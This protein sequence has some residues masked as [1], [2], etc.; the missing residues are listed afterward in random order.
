VHAG[1]TE[2]NSKPVKTV[3][4]DIR[5][6][7]T[8]NRTSNKLR[9]GIS[10]FQSTL[11][12]KKR[13]VDTMLKKNGKRNRCYTTKCAAETGRA[14]N[15]DKV[16]SGEI[17]SIKKKKSK[18][19][20]K[21]D[22][23]KYVVQVSSRT[24]YRI[25]LHVTDVETGRVDLTVK[26]ESPTR[27]TD[28][29][30]KNALVK[31]GNYFDKVKRERDNPFSFNNLSW[32]I[33]GS[34]ILTHGLFRDM[35]ESGY[36][37]KVRPETRN[38]FY[39]NSVFQF[40]ASYNYFTG[41]KVSY[42][43]FSLVEIG[44]LAGYSVDVI[45]LFKIVPLIGAGYNIYYMKEDDGKKNFYYDPQISAVVDINYLLMS[46]L[47]LVVSPAYTLFFEKDD[48]GKYFGVHTGVSVIF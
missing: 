30:V 18:T 12:V 45:R 13:D 37:I 48:V 41:G 8:R 47:R 5:D 17:R 35:A 16:I 15:A 39:K 3:F 7:Y 25:L 26:E 22:S 38:V 9:R 28:K 36:G 33:Q 27:R 23:N 34:Y 20:K 4:L 40:S 10:Q 21:L 29:A 19:L 31:I 14:L 2:G 24:T 46:N 11:L 32:N 6:N 42:K 43:N 1:G 44:L